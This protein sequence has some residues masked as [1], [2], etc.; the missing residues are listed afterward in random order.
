[1]R[2]RLVVHFLR[3]HRLCLDCNVELGASVPI[4][5]MEEVHGWKL[6]CE[7]CGFQSLDDRNVHRKACA[8][9]A[10]KIRESDKNEIISNILGKKIKR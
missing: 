10:M 9:S 6:T 3:F 4:D 7:F 5:H 1:M 8:K 2:K